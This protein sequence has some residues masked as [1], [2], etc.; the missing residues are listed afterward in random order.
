MKLLVNWYDSEGQE[1]EH[2]DL[3]IEAANHIVTKLQHG[4]T[5]G[6]LYATGDY[7]SRDGVEAEYTGSWKIVF[8]KR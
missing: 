6:D 1:V 2:C 4:F 3:A 7:F 5:S 8:E